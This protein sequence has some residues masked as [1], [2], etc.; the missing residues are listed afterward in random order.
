M[1]MAMWHNKRHNRHRLLHIAAALF[2]L[3]LGVLI[4]VVSRD[5]RQV[6]F[7]GYL[8]L[9]NNGI[10]FP[11][12]S[13]LYSLP[14]FL[15]IYAFILLSSVVMSGRAKRR[16]LIVVLWLVIEI[17]FELGQ[18]HAIATVIVA[19]LPAWFQ[20]HSLLRAL[21]DYFM[22]GRF[23]LLDVAGLILGALAAYLTLAVSAPAP[24]GTAGDQHSIADR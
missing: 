9:I 21:G 16:W 15:H 8:P 19:A 17:L 20:D 23:D 10:L 5:P 1:A 12:S 18:Q 2:A 11:S 3:L 13:L 22:S 7:L 6:F 4:Y 24:T 14:S